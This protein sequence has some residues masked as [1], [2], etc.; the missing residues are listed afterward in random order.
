MAKNTDNQDKKSAEEHGEKEQGEAGGQCA[1]F[2]FDPAF[3]LI[4]PPV[5]V[6]MPEFMVVKTL[7][8]LGLT[9]ATAESCTGGLLA[10]R[11]TD[12]SGSSEV[13]EMGLVTYANRVKTQLLNVPEEVLEKHGAVSEEVAILMAKNVRELAKS[14]F[15]IGITGIAGPN[16]GS[17]EK[18]VG[19]VYICLAARE[20]LWLATMYPDGARRKR[21][22]LR[23][24]A[25]TN[26][27]EMLAGALRILSK[28]DGD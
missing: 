10:K 11:I 24:E 19:L 16:G 8:R 26:A 18:P 28:K 20:R 7:A 23:E 12:I 4:F 22:D 21:E 14:D 13:F 27:L 3:P 5:F 6:P 15:G 1:G 17:L 9:V 25:A 2:F